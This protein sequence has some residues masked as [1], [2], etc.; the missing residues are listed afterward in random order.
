MAHTKFSTRLL[1]FGSILSKVSSEKWNL[2]YFFSNRSFCTSDYQRTQCCRRVNQLR[3]NSFHSTNL[4]PMQNK[5]CLKHPARPEIYTTCRQPIYN[6]LVARA[7]LQNLYLDNTCFHEPF[8]YVAIL[9]G[10]FLMFLNIL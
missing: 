3:K 9:P 5:M 10:F 1:S 2:L 7:E 8:A 6:H 4:E